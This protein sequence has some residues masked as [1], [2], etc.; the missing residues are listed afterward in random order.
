M[1]AD[2][3]STATASTMPPHAGELRDHFVP[4]GLLPESYTMPPQVFIDVGQ[5]AEASSIKSKA[6]TASE[7]IESLKRLGQDE[8]ASVIAKLSQTASWTTSI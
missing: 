3:L 1:Q 4:A 6:A 5:S 2:T 7:I 8:A